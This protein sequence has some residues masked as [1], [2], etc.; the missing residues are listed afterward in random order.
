[1]EVVL[2]PQIVTLPKRVSY[3]PLSGRSDVGLQDPPLA[4]L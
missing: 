4:T 1:V 3:G 2:S